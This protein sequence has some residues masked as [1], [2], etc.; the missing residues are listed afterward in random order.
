MNVSRSRSS[1]STD[2]WSTHRD[3]R[4]TGTAIEIWHHDLTPG[5]YTGNDVGFT[6]RWEDTDEWDTTDYRVA[7][8]Q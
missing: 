1:R 7:I 4:G 3:S 6:F 8:Q 5:D 2:D